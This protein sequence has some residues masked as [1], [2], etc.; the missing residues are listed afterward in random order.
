MSPELIAILTAIV[1]LALAAF[2][3]YKSKT[4]LTVAGVQQALIDGSHTATE[5]MAIV[6][7]AVFAAEQL[8]ATGK[9]PDNNAAFDYAFVQ[10]SKLL[11]NL[12]KS[13]L[14]MFI[15]SAVPLA[16]QMSKGKGTNS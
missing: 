10:A 16:N 6:Q 14:T 2:T 9:L 7:S 3:L 13:T 4:P 1:A 8:K 11:P 15:E 5:A 12:D